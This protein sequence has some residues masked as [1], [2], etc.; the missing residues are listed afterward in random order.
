MRYALVVSTISSAGNF[1]ILVKHFLLN[2]LAAT[3][4]LVE[5]HLSVISKNIQSHTFLASSMNAFEE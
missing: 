3:K 1:L 4:C 2:N 5:E